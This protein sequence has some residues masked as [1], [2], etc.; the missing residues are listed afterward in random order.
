M[1]ITVAAPAK[2]NLYLD[3]L[4]K[5]NDGYHNVKMIMQTVSLFDYITV[6]K[7]SNCKIN[8]ISNFKFFSPI[9]KNTAYIAAQKFFQHTKIKN[10]G[11]NVYIDKKIPICAGLAGGSSDAAAVLVA[12]NKL[13]DTKLSKCTLANIGRE[14]G[15]DVPFCILGGTMLAYDTGT[16]LLPLPH[17]DDCFI[18]LVKPKVHVS[19]K[20]A[21]TASDSVK[22]KIQ[23]NISPIIKSIKY[24]N[25]KSVSRLLYNRFEHILKIKDVGK[26]KSIFF[27]LGAIGS[28]MS[29]SG[30]AVFGIFNNEKL[31][32]RCLHILSKRYKETFLVHPIKTGCFIKSE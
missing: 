9:E 32:R 21:Y 28:C 27:S 29:G 30:S 11:I 16:S 26:L 17:L 13:F 15:A 31:A 24:H 12:L 7:S 19:T 3:I 22:L 6:T 20:N 4:N 2:I 5:R 18:V 25:L 8:I 10:P 23:R 1:K 14:I